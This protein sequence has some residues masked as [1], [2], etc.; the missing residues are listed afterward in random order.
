MVGYWGTKPA[1]DYQEGSMSYWR[2]R[3]RIAILGAV[4]VCAICSGALAAPWAGSGD[5]N[6]PYQI[7]DANDMQAIG[8]DSNYWD[9]HFVLC[10][11]IN[12]AAYTGTSFNIIG[13]YVNNISFA[14]V[15]DGN[16]HTIWNFTYSDSNVVSG[17][18]LFSYTGGQNA[19]IRELKLADPNINVGAGWVVGS[20]V[21][22]SGRCAVTGCH[23]E[24][25]RV[26]GNFYVGGLVG[27]NGSDLFQSYCSARVSGNEYVGGL[28]G[29]SAVIISNCRSNNVVSGSGNYIGGLV[30][31]NTG[32]IYDSNSTGSV[33]G[34]TYVGGLVGKN[35]TMGTI[36]NS[37]S[38]ADVS[39][40]F[41]VGGLVGLNSGNIYGCYSAN[42]NSGVME[43]IGGLV[44]R[45]EEGEIWNCY[46][47]SDVCGFSDIGGLLG[48]NYEGFVSNSYS[49]GNVSGVHR[50]STGGLVGSNILGTVINSFWDVNS[51]DEPNSAGGTGKTTTEMQTRST[52]TDAGWDFVGEVV[53][54]PN[55]IW[56]ICEGTNYPKF[57]WQIPAADFVC[58]DGVTMVDFSVLGAAWY[59]D[60]NDYSWD[61]N[62][63][64]SEPNDSFIDEKDL[65]VFSESWL[66]GV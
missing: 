38:I 2:T 58:P 8:A 48:R 28:A 16:G 53:N 50:Y 18:G 57:V 11:D 37:Y 6:D 26:S 25:G 60:P 63:D 64:I 21:G 14:G 44:G 32:N 46:S 34:G 13:D 52:F 12:L 51:S 33:D 42:T 35:R 45:N 30:G 17:V 19:E 31:E 54:G 65:R 7:W 49:T 9:S 36:S 3:L 66:E 40:N 27:E 59:S 39:G 22:H 61:P 29:Y 15:F 41:Y 23:V 62:C 55:D 56:D 10:V 4:L 5:A 1:E 24:G 20:L 43:E 47:T